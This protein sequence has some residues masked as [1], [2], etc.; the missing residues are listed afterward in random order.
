MI[1]SKYLYLKMKQSEKNILLGLINKKKN[2]QTRRLRKM[3]FKKLLMG[4]ALLSLLTLNCLGQL[5]AVTQKSAVTITPLLEVRGIISF[6]VET[7]IQ[8][9]I[10]ITAKGRPVSGLEVQF[11][12]IKIPEV[13]SRPGEYQLSYI[14]FPEPTTGQTLHLKISSRAGL[15]LTATAKFDTKHIRFITPKWGDTIILPTITKAITAR[16]IGGAPPPYYSVSI[17]PLPYTPGTILEERNYPNQKITFKSSILLPGKQYKLKVRSCDF[18]FTFKEKV[19][20]T[21]RMAFYL[22]EYVLFNTKAG[23][24]L[25]PVKKK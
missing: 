21:S 19:A 12:K 13:A 18:F 16:W 4:T 23:P 1:I 20:P 9:G 15:K 8:V 7:N 22:S 14:R 5:K 11:E 25:V 24:G 10:N 2:K 17:R 3:N 6:G